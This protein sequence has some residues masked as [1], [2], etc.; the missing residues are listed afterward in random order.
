MTTTNDQSQDIFVYF[1]K[2]ILKVNDVN[3]IAKA[4]E[5]ECVENFH[6]LWQL[7]LDELENL[8]YLN[9]SGTRVDIPKSAGTLLNLLRYF[10]RD[11]IEPY[12]RDFTSFNCEEFEEYCNDHGYVLLDD[13]ADILTKESDPSSPS[14]SEVLFHHIFKNILK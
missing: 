12:K 3:S 11:N 6:D 9:E 7:R 1:F 8:H 2:D 4:L 5:Y 13:F 10:V 14:E